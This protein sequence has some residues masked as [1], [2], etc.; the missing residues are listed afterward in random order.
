[1]QIFLISKFNSWT[2]DVFTVKSIQFVGGFG[3]PHHTSVSCTLENDWLPIVMLQNPACMRFSVSYY[4]YAY[5]E[6]SIYE[7]AV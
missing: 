5:I 7:S 3:F 6:T 2:Q 1:M 4:Q